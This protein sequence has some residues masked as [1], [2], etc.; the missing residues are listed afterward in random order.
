M[1]MLIAILG[2]IKNSVVAMVARITQSRRIALFSLWSFNQNEAGG[3]QKK[4]KK[5]EEETRCSN[6]YLMKRKIF[7]MIAKNIIKSTNVS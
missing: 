7:F 1:L 3:K 6:I 2:R 5:K 4:K